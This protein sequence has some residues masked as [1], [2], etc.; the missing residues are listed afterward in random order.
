[1]PSFEKINYLLR[2]SKQV[3]RKL[4]LETMQKLSEMG[5]FLHEYTY[6]GFGS[7][8][9][10]DFILFHK[11]L[12][13]TEMIC[14]EIN[15]IEKRMLF[16]KPYEFINLEMKSAGS[17][18]PELNREKR[19][20][21]WLDYDYSLDVDILSDLR[22]CL[23]VLAPGSILIISLSSELRSLQRKIDINVSKKMKY[24]EKC[25]WVIEYLNDLVGSYYGTE[26]KNS[27]LAQN[28]LPPVMAKSI[29]NFIRSCLSAR[30]NMTFYQ[31][32]NYLYSDGTQMLTIGGI[33]DNSDREEKFEESNI[34]SLFSVTKDEIPIQIS[35]PPLTNR[36]KLWLDQ[37]VMQLKK[38]IT[39]H[40]TLP[41]SMAFEINLDAINNYE[42]PEKRQNRK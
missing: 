33:I 9:Y 22:S 2:P 13:I 10:A 5:Y 4:M 23:H 26:I 36:E 32:F 34:Y 14:A 29:R 27:H 39:E 11:Y 6:F 24:S 20:L 30:E 16:N 7:I 35:V 21:V 17:I 37:N 40:S 31:L 42:L 25:A 28:N 19:H 3:E 38:Y 15:N 1:M 12:H 18:I 8:Y 41:D